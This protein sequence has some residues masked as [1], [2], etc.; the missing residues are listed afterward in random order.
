MGNIDDQHRNPNM[1]NKDHM[2]GQLTNW[3]I[4]RI[5]RGSTTAPKESLA[6]SMLVGARVQVLLFVLNRSTEFRLAQFSSEPPK[7]NNI[8]SPFIVI[9]AMW[10][11]ALGEFKSPT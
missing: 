5:S 7:A 3:G 6:S 9:V 11:Y 10:K 2:V 4:G 8:C 1:N